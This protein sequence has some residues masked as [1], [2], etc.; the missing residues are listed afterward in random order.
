MPPS[1]EAV[2]SY[3]AG[4]KMDMFNRMV[5]LNLAGYILNRTGTQIDFDNAEAHSHPK[6]VSVRRAN[7]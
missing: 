2:K 3:E 5:R 1:P 4:A 7:L 6:S